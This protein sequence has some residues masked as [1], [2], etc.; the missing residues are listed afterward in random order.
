M[1]LHDVVLPSF[2]R[3]ASLLR[4]DVLDSPRHSVLGG[5][6]HDGG[7]TQHGQD[8]GQD[9]AAV[10]ETYAFLLEGGTASCLLAPRGGVSC[11]DRPWGRLFFVTS[12]AL[13]KFYTIS[14]G[15]HTP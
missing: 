6:G 7:D 3:E 11:S 5:Q 15:C 1:Q 8:N 2:D 4:V 9:L 12:Y 10:C 14:S 13:S